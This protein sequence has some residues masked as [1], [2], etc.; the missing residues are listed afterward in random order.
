[1]QIGVDIETTVADK[2]K[3]HKIQRKEKIKARRS[4]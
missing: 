2:L 1:M 4:R 3:I